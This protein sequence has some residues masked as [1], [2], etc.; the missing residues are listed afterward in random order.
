MDPRRVE[1]SVWFPASYVGSRAAFGLLPPEVLDLPRADTGRSLR[2][3][4]A[5]LGLRPEAVAR[6]ERLLDP[7][8][9]HGFVEM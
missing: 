3:H 6:G 2:D 7:A 8:G 9:I 5:E 4:M 1:E